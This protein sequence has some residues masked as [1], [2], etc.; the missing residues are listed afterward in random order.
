MEGFLE[1]IAAFGHGLGA[2]CETDLNASVAD[3]VGDV[4]NCFETGGAEAVDRRGGGGVGEASCEGCGTD[5]VGGFSVVDLCPTSEKCF[6]Q[7]DWGSIHCRDKYPLPSEDLT[8]I[9]Q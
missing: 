6:L 1:A 2:D 3:L 5:K 8:W 9:Y 7:G 4:L